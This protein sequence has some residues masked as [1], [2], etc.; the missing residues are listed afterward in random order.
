MLII[1]ESTPRKR[2]LNTRFTLESAMKDP[3]GQIKLWAPSISKIVSVIVK[4]VEIFKFNFILKRQCSMPL[5]NLT[6]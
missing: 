5:P 2:F 1:Y 4:A 6:P 3:V